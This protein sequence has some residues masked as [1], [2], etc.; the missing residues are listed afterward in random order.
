MSDVNAEMKATADYA[1]K[2][3][4]S[5]YNLNLDY[6]KE[7]IT[8]LDGILEKMYWGFSSRIND[9]GKDGLIYNTAIIWGS[10]LGEYMLLNW[11]GSW[12]L[13]G[14]QQVVLIKNKEFSPISFV[15]QKITGHFN[16]KL[17]DYLSETN[18]VVG[19][20]QG[21]I[22]QE[23]YIQNY[24]EALEK[25]IGH[26][27]AKK[28]FIT[29]RKLI[30]TASISGILIVLTV[31]I[32]VL[33]NLT[34]G[35]LPAFGSLETNT[36]TPTDT[37]TELAPVIP[38]DTPVVIP[39]ATVTPLPTYTIMPTDTPQPT[40][41]ASLTPTETPSATPTETETPIPSDT[42][43]PYR[44]PTPT[45]TR[46]PTKKPPTSTHTSAPTNTATQVPP[47]TNTQP[48]P[49]T[50][51]SCG[52]NPSTVNAGEPTGLT[53]VVQFSAPGYGMNIAGFSPDLGSGQAGCSD[54]NTDGDTTASCQGNSGLLP[55]SQKVDVTISTPLGNCTVSYHSTSQ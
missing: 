42:P 20:E 49:P 13:K 43:I 39:S 55:Y 50:I 54:G 44:S 30:Y 2:S 29:K 40:S 15:Y 41:T 34:K 37:P 24:S 23:Q 7:S 31:C 9:Q 25:K 45:K 28:P 51:V 47:P 52:V 32:I 33:V 3:A 16:Y 1:V 6:S 26:P 5:R 11:G 18:Q 38:V 53:F 27:Q 48:P 12:K 46:T 22:K 10:Y 8:S 21:S 17:E 14:T 36:A 19:P 4:K 35:G